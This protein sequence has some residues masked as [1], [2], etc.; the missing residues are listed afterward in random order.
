MSEKM[1]NYNLRKFVAT[2]LIIAMILTNSGF[3]VLADI[4]DDVATEATIE[5]QPSHSL[6]YEEM[7]EENE[8]T[9]LEEPEE[10]EATNEV[11]ENYETTTTEEETS[12]E[13]SNDGEDT[14]SAIEDS[15]SNET[16]ATVENNIVDSEMTVAT[17]SDVENV[18]DFENEVTTTNNVSDISDVL[19]TLLVA[20]SSV[21]TDDEAI[22]NKNVELATL[23]DLNIIIEDIASLSELRERISPLQLDTLF[24]SPA[25]NDVGTLKYPAPD[26]CP[27][28]YSEFDNVK[29]NEIKK[30]MIDSQKA[31]FGVD[32]VPANYD[33]WN[34]NLTNKH[35][36][37]KKNIKMQVGT[38][39]NYTWTDKWYIDIYG[40]WDAGVITP[41]WESLGEYNIGK[42]RTYFIPFIVKGADR[43]ELDDSVRQRD[44]AFEHLSINDGTERKEKDSDW[45]FGLNSYYTG[46]WILRDEDYFHDEWNAEWRVMWYRDG[47]QPGFYDS[48]P[49]IKSF[50]NNIIYGYN[51]TYNQIQNDFIFNT[52]NKFSNMNLTEV[53]FRNTTFRGDSFDNQFSNMQNLTKV[54][55]SPGTD[56]SEIKS[57]KEMF[58]NCSSLTTLDLSDA[59]LNNLENAESMFEGCT[60]LQTIDFGN[61][62][63]SHLTNTRYMFKGCT[64]LRTIKIGSQTVNLSQIADSVEMFTGCENL[65]G[66]GGYKFNENFTD[67]TFA[68]VDCGSILPGY[69]TYTGNDPI[70]INFDKIDWSIET[71][72]LIKKIEFSTASFIVI[73][74]FLYQFT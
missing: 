18:E 51:E 54:T 21:S 26:V 14:S 33:N 16:I 22:S 53:E 43:R 4:I 11:V 52:E 59:L 73:M 66:G 5:D 6:Y 1:S 32:T 70:I 25:T 40:S 67:G 24:D 31:V 65:I 69:F 13:V 50:E 55:F 20:T 74:I 10:D 58:K 27:D 3:F 41:F 36:W 63:F 39:Y 46:Y 48:H 2:I 44:D 34:W 42:A 56:V 45:C 49:E 7:L 37:R 47:R 38:S 64:N 29:W 57:A 71:K 35:T 19:A 60:N 12:T 23:S 61:I 68:R 8:I 17:S 9:T 72:E 62:N 28:I 30:D 15:T